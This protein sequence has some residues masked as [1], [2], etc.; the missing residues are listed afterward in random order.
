MVLPSKHSVASLSE[1]E[2]W[3]PKSMSY[4]MVVMCIDPEE[5]KNDEDDETKVS[6]AETRSNQL[7]Y[8]LA[9]GSFALYLLFSVLLEIEYVE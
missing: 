8:L 1:P 7:F 4:L 3:V 2:E 6:P 9:G 5:N